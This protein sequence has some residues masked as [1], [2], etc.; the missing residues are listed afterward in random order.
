MKKYIIILK[1][2]KLIKQ[3]FLKYEKNIIYSYY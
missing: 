1:I 3:N 2:I